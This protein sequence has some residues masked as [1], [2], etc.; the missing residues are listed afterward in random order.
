MVAGLRRAGITGITIV[1][2][3]PRVEV[4]GCDHVDVIGPGNMVHSLLAASDAATSSEDLLVCYSDLVVEQRLLTALLR[5]RIDD[6]S[7]FVCVDSQW[8]TYYRWRFDGSVGDAESLEVRDGLIADVGH[9]LDA[10]EQ[11][12]CGQYVGLLR[13]SRQGF[14]GLVSAWERMADPEIYMTDALR[15][16]VSR[17][18]RLVPVWVAG[19]WL[20]LDSMND[21]RGAVAVLDGSDRVPFFDPGG[22]P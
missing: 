7:C 9:P 19:G 3:D 10:Q 4:E 5:P 12:P 1:R 15:E 14:R 13:F 8:Q 21:Y 18:H 11:L 22:L 17:D 6:A 20:E 16:M 2:T